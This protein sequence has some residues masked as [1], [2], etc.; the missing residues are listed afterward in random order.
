MLSLLGSPPRAA[1]WKYRPD[2]SSAMVSL[3]VVG[4]TAYVL[5]SVVFLYWRVQVAFT[6]TKLCPR[7]SFATCFLGDS[8]AQ[9]ADQAF[10]FGEAEARSSRSSLTEV[11]KEQSSSEAHPESSPQATSDAGPPLALAGGKGSCTECGTAEVQQIPGS[12]PEFADEKPSHSTRPFPED[13]LP[14]AQQQGGRR[15]KPPLWGVFGSYWVLKVLEQAAESIDAALKESSDPAGIGNLGHPDID[16]PTP[17]SII[18]TS[19]LSIVQDSLDDSS[20]GA[21][22]F[23]SSPL[24]VLSLLNIMAIFAVLLKVLHCQWPKEGWSSSHSPWLILGR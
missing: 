9:N 1:P 5:A 7:A 17:S 19:G 6:D 3:R 15:G 20:T 4:G 18:D 11:P 8:K 13:K 2:I 10:R 21:S 24:T 22:T 23:L 12:S 14:T 16:R